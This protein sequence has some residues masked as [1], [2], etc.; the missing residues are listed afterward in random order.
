MPP[1]SPSSGGTPS[2]EWWCHTF[3]YGKESPVRVTVPPSAGCLR[4]V[5]AAATRRVVGAV[6]E[7]GPR[8]RRF[9]G[10]SVEGGTTVALPGGLAGDFQGCGGATPEHG[11]AA[12][13][14]SVR[15]ELTAGGLD[16]FAF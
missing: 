8:R 3:T 6:P 11:P 14:L 16:H 12:L 5:F 15:L 10:V 7:R 4:A 2:V 1:E 9:A 13:E